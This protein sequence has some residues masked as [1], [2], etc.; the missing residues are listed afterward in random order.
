MVDHCRQLQ[1]AGDD[2]L[3]GLTYSSEI[4]TEAGFTYSS[5]IRTEAGFT[6]SSGIRTEAGFTYSSEIRTESGFTYSSGIRTEAG[7]TYSSGIITVASS[8]SLRKG[9]ISATCNASNKSLISG[10]ADLSN[11]KN[12]T[13]LVI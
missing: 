10:M 2:L 8:L 1:E 12:I 7:F 3:M 13:M 4:R 9:K 5:G 6:Y 11:H